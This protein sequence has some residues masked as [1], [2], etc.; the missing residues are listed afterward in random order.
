MEKASSH[1]YKSR[2]KNGPFFAHCE[3]INK[4][5][6][7]RSCYERFTYWFNRIDEQNIY[8]VHINDSQYF[9]GDH[10]RGMNAFRASLILL[11]KSANPA[12]LI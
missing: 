2:H 9:S 3:R 1:V 11:S 7:A 8:T 4:T 10:M 5:N 6:R 12:Q